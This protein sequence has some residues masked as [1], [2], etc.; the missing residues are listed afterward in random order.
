MR[1]AQAEQ[2]WWSREPAA[3]RGGVDLPVPH[4]YAAYA[5]IT[6]PGGRR[7]RKYVYGKDRED[8]A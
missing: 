4:G 7:Q 1:A 2:T 3:Q 6:T 5:W 8:G